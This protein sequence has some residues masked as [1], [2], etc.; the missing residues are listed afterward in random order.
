MI[1]R[2]DIIKRS[3]EVTRISTWWL[4]EAKW[5]MSWSFTCGGIED[6]VNETW[7]RLLNQNLNVD[8]ELSTVVVTATRWTLSALTRRTKQSDFNYQLWRHA[9]R[10]YPPVTIEGEADE[11]VNKTELSEAVERVLKSLTYREREV[12]KLRLGIGSDSHTLEEAASVFGVSRERIRQI[13]SKAVEKL[14]HHTRADYLKGF[15][16]TRKQIE[17][18]EVAAAERSKVEIEWGDIQDISQ[19]KA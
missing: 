5:R 12:L 10:C 9:E 11:S 8:A 19:E 15:L 4:T 17:A 14:Q 6:V 7:V 16:D 3:E 2:E 1:T 13:E 18:E